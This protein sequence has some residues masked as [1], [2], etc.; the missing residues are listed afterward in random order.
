MLYHLATFLVKSAVE[1]LNSHVFFPLRNI[2]ADHGILLPTGLTEI[3][4]YISPDV[5]IATATTN[6]SQGAVERS[7]CI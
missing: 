7:E 2:N 3:L 6:P 1:R 4:V 5:S